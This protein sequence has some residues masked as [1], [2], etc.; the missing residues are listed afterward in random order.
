MDQRIALLQPVKTY[1]STTNAEV[2]TYTTAGNVRAERIFKNSSERYEA[3]QQVGT[4]TQEF[5]IRDY[6]SIYT[7]TQQWRFT[8]DNKTYEIRGIEKV[9]RRNFLILTGEV[10]D[11]G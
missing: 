8:W 6:S 7:I 5:R 11:N 2:I 9:G 3:Q 10:R 4:T 1:D